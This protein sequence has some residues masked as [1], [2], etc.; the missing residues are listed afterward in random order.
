MEKQ[1][2]LP[3]DEEFHVRVAKLQQLADEIKQ[4]FDYENMADWDWSV[5]DEYG[6]NWISTKT[7]TNREL[8]EIQRRLVDKYQNAAAFRQRAQT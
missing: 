4:H 5:F 1:C 6:N 3:L 8:K 7:I 2:V